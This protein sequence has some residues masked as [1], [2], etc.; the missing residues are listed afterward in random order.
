MNKINSK[1]INNTKFEA[2]KPKQTEVTAMK[3]NVKQMVKKIAV[4]A[5]REV[6]EYGDFLP[7]YEEFKN[8]DKS[9]KASDFMLKIVKTHSSIE[10][11]ETLRNLELVAYKLPSPYIAERVL[12]SGTREEIIEALKDPALLSKIQSATESLS[13]SLDDI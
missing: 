12:A 7:V 2:V 10:G 11:H 9:L 3:D 4:R 6:P 5:E 8:T 1:N 13:K